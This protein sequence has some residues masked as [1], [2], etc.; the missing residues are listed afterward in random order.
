MCEKGFIVKNASFNDFTFCFPFLLSVSISN[1]GTVCAG[2]G[3]SRVGVYFYSPALQPASRLCCSQGSPADQ[4][5]SRLSVLPPNHEGPF[6]S[7]AVR[8]GPGTCSALME[9][10]LND[11]PE[12]KSELVHAGALCRVRALSL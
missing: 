3:S 5:S 2:P 8:S 6:V 9:H 11:C 7:P 10:Y 1:R 12:L 4:G